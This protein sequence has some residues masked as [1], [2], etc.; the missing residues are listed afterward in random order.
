MLIVQ[1]RGSL[2]GNCDY[3]FT[4]GSPGFADGQVSARSLGQ[5]GLYLRGHKDDYPGELA[6][7]FG[8]AANFVR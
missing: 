4:G 3:R 8:Y 1:G 6:T 5:V 2:L 7:T